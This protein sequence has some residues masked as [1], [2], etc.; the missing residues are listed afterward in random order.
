[1]H[2]LS[3]VMSIVEI[4]EKET[5]KA[6]AH[7]V[8]EINLDIGY[9]ST[10]EIEAFEFAWDVA[11]KNTVLEHSNKKINRIAGKGCCNVCNT[12]FAIAQFY[13]PCPFCN[14]HSITIIKGKELRVKTLVLN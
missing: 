10:I 3:I 12:E 4:A 8:E 11:V 2:E 1:M 6:N 5:A 7:S 9:L 14:S 13:D